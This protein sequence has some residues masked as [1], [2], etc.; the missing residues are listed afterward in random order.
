MF[1]GLG[2]SSLA[3]RITSATAQSPIL[4]GQPLTVTVTVY[5]DSWYDW[6][7]WELEYSWGF[8]CYTPSDS[9]LG[10]A[11][12]S[13][14]VSS[15]ASAT[16]SYTIDKSFLPTSPGTYYVQVQ[17]FYNY[18]DMWY[19]YTDDSPTNVY[20][21]VN[22]GNHAPTITAIAD[23]VV[24]ETNLLSFTVSATDT[25]TPPQILTY[26]L[27]TGAPAGASINSSNGL[28]TWTPP[29]GYAPRT[30]QISVI[31]TDNGSP[32]MSATNTF[33]VIVLKPLR[34]QPPAKP[35]NGAMRLVWESYPGKN[36][37][38]RY[39]DNLIS[40]TWT[41]IDVLATGSPTSATNVLGNTKQRYYELLLMD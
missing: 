7:P 40:G 27:G 21:T 32:A 15:Y 34:F 19:F 30:N 39:R 24:V 25:D 2:Q 33:N 17:A 22:A 23:K 26:S 1:C 20:F 5:N 36:Y 35:I 31:V 9:Y 38:V 10:E 3:Q 28:F 16:L 41:N 18:L 8:E 14:Y 11:D 12:S 29:A 4:V 37:R 6:D 13:A